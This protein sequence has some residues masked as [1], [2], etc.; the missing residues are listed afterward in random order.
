VYYLVRSVAIT[1]TAIVGGVLWAIA[2]A[3]PFWVAGGVS[4]V[5]VA[6]FTATVDERYAA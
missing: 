4:L 3:L 1:P 6:V 2:P 5:G